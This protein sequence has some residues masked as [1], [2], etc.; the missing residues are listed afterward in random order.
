MALKGSI[1]P[2]GQE[3]E[4]DKALTLHPY[5]DHRYL[6][7]TRQ[8]LHQSNL[9]QLKK[10]KQLLE[11]SIT[12]INKIIGLENDTSPTRE[13]I[14]KWHIA[15][16]KKRRYYDSVGSYHV[17]RHHNKAIN[18][19]LSLLNKW[20]K[21]EGRRNSLNSYLK[22]ENYIY[23]TLHP[24]EGHMN[25]I[26]ARVRSEITGKK[27]NRMYIVNQRFGEL[28]LDGVGDIYKEE[29]ASKRINFVIPLYGKN[30]A[31]RKFMK[32]FEETVLKTGENVSLLV[33]CFK[34]G[35]NDVDFSEV[36]RTMDYLKQKYP[37]YELRL[38]AVIGEFQ[39]AIALQKASDEFP[40]NALLFLVDIDCSIEQGLLHRIRQ[41]THQGKQVYFP[42]MFSQY[43]PEMVKALPLSNETLKGNVIELFSNVKGYWRTFSYGQVALYKSDLDNAGGFN[44]NIKGWGKEDIDFAIRI[45]QKE[46]TIFRST[47]NGLIHIYHKINCDPGL[48]E[49][50]HIMCQGTRLATYGSDQIL[51]EIIYNNSKLQRHSRK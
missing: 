30:E 14:C 23:Q 22:H 8:Y 19:Y 48:P 29:K 50:Q 16:E 6:Y 24:I 44:T 49:D 17:P 28:E 43:D 36:N 4:I 46:I 10:H 9:T 27:E 42:I 35:R 18:K 7:K 34:T 2:E 38:I 11:D 1:K 31:F 25:S 20:L 37:S 26:N 15:R 32:K 39:R 33:T 21:D 45:V 51:S 47:D 40:D 41:N 12:E 5:K 3:K 13:D